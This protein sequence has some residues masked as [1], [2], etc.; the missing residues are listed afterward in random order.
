VRAGRLDLI[1]SLALEQGSLFSIVA[2]WKDD[3]DALIN[4]TGYSARMQLRKDYPSSAAVVDIT[5]AN[6]GQ[7]QLV[8]GGAAGTINIRIQDE[9]TATLDPGRY[10]YDLEVKASGGDWQRLLEGVADVMPEVTR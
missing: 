1:D 4:L 6:S 7:G 10:V 2:T 3:A 9:H 8:L 5:E